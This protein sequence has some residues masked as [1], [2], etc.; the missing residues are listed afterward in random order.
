VADAVE[1]EGLLFEP[2]GRRLLKGFAEPVRVSALV[3]RR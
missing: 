1:V 2:A 3:D